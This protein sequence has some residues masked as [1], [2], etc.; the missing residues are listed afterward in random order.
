MIL[1]QGVTDPPVGEERS[2]VSSL[3][4]ARVIDRMPGN[5]LVDGSEA[6]VASVVKKLK[7]W[8]FSPVGSAGIRPPHKM[9]K[10]PV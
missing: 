2:L 6:E 7:Q 1:Y 5:I 3:K 4:R 10:Q 9:L 8:T